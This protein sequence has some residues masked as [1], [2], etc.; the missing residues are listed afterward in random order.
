MHTTQTRVEHLHQHRQHVLGAHQA[1]VEQGKAGDRHQQHQHGRRQHPGDVALVGR[2]RCRRLG[3][4]GLDHEPRRERHDCKSC[5]PAR[6]MPSFMCTASKCAAANVTSGWIERSDCAVVGL[7]RAD[8]HGLFDGRDEDLAVADLAGSGRADDGLD[9]LVHG[10]GR[11]HDLD[12]H[13]RQEAHRVFGPA[14]DLRMPFLTAVTFDLGHGHALAA[15][16]R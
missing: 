15:R 12:L 7:A 16:G 9:S 11:H 2:R 3:Q 6:G 4:G 14:V 1:A 5:N 8:A 10:A 13:L